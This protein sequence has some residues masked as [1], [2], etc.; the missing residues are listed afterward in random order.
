MRKSKDT[1]VFSSIWEF[2]KNCVEKHFDGDRFAIS[3]LTAS[4]L[5]VVL[6]VTGFKTY[7][8]TLTMNMILW[9]HIMIIPLASGR[10]YLSHRIKNISN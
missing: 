1:G 3:G 9:L 5:T 4:L 10:L 7:E 6:I 2:V 8:S